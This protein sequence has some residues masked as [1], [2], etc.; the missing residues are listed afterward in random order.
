MHLLCSESLCLEREVI[1]RASSEQGF[2]RGE[3]WYAISL[4][5][6]VLELGV[7][8]WRG[9]KENVLLFWQAQG[10]W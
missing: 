9:G 2:C 8:T 5:A 7:G 4:V 6:F 10:A 1:D 3:L